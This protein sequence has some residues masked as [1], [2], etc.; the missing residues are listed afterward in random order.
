MTLRIVITILV[1]VVVFIVTV[2][3]AMADSSDYPGVFFW[4]T[5]VMV[6]IMNSRSPHFLKT[7]YAK[8]KP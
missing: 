5:M 4:T 8:P 3:M 6:V 2:I 7:Q 1:E